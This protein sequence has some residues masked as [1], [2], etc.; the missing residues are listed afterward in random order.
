MIAP[1][2]PF[3]K[4]ASDLTENSNIEV[5]SQN[6]N[7]NNSGAFTGEVSV[8]MLKSIGLSTTLIGHSERDHCI[9]K[10]MIYCLKK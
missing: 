3:L 5:I 1:S 8:K 10:T 4:V 7:E 6:V 2:Y 9:M